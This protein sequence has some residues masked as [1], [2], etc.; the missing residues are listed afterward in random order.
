LTLRPTLR[1]LAAL[2]LIGLA[3][4]AAPA[5]AGDAP[6]PAGPKLTGVVELFTSQGC[7]SCPPADKVLAEIGARPDIVALAYHVDYWDYLGWR[8]TLGTPE[9]SARQRGYMRA[10][11]I[12]AVYTP[13]AVVNGRMHINGSNRDGL[14][15]ALKEMSLAGAGLV[16]PLSVTQEGDA[17]AI[18]AGAIDP[19]SCPKIGEAALLL[20]FF[21]APEPV[22]IASGENEGHTITYWNPVAAVQPV[23]LWRRK[24]MRFEL[25]A[26]ALKEGMGAVLLL[27]ALD[28]DG[29][30]G[31]ILGAVVVRRPGDS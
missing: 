8:D 6:K 29:Q 5:M 1:R 12:R 7:N 3:A 17:I 26:G 14:F 31:A 28:R 20:V 10:F 2:F 15:R 13:Q 21:R 22:E 24:A 19:A 4:L 30:P 11:K 9:N 27:Q 25:P 18:E 16:V 23:G